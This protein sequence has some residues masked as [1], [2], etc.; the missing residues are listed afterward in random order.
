MNAKLWLRIFLLLFVVLFLAS[1]ALVISVDPFFHYNAP[2]FDRYFYPLDNE[3][4]MNS[5]IT[6]HFDYDAVI[7]GTSMTANFRT[8]ELDA[9][10]GTQSIK[11][12]SAGATYYELNNLINGALEQ[13][14][15]LK[16]VIRSV[17]RNQLFFGVNELRDDLGEFP[18]Y[19]YDENI[20]NDYEYLFNSDIIFGRSLSMMLQRG[21]EGFIPGHTS[22]DYYS[23]TMEY[24]SGTF[25]LEEARGYTNFE[26][27]NL[28]E[29]QHL[30]EE[31]QAQVIENVKQNLVAT[32]LEHPDTT[33]YYF[34]PPYSLGFWY[35]KLSSGEIYAQFEAEK[36]AIELML[37]CDNIRLYD[38]SGRTDIISDPNNYRD[39]LHY[40]DWVN[41]LMLKWMHDDQYRLTKDNYEDFLSRQFDYYLSADYEAFSNQERYHCDYYAAALVNEELRGIEPRPIPEAELLSGELCNAEFISDPDNGESILRCSGTLGRSPEQDL[42]MYLLYA[43]YSGLKLSIPD[44]DKYSYIVV[45]GRN[46]GHHGQPSIFAYDENGAVISSTETNYYK[47][48]GGWQLFAVDIREARGPVTVIFNGAYSDDTGHPASSFEFKDF[49]LY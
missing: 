29:A 14:P 6:K 43:D 42:G 19:L 37:D 2:K 5:G 41:S 12:P 22:F 10:F 35:E 17:D 31:M 40:G 8:S 24:Y 16:Y 48:A 25:G 13:N 32:A 21:E 38:F 9:L 49:E 33:F 30:S 47:L 27:E 18:A 28:P 26:P 15:E 3:R 23:N 34:L 4:S 45:K 1:A 7:A 44:G 36:L 11:L 39:L 46:T 20:F